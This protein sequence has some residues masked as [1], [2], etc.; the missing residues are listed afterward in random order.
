MV[1]EVGIPD[2]IFV[3][4]QLNGHRFREPNRSGH[5]RNDFQTPS[6]ASFNARMK[7]IELWVIRA[8]DDSDD[9]LL[10]RLIL[11]LKNDSQ[12]FP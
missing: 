5:K 11:K 3:K 7:D 6:L 12:C 10:A 4:G 2:A 9:M 1:A 8:N